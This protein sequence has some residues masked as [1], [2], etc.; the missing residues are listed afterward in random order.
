MWQ[1]VSARGAACT[2]DAV[3][4]N[5]TVVL[6]PVLTK[7]HTKASAVLVR[8]CLFRNPMNAYMATFVDVRD[9]AAAIAAALLR[10]AA[11]GERFLLVSDDPP[12]NTLELGAIA[13][14]G[15]PSPSP[16]PSPS[17]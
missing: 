4:I 16:S 10:P 11:A 6:G 8:E 14:V 17:P 13:Q 9:V 7:A 3:A 15:P 2:F 1:F 5:P 12:M